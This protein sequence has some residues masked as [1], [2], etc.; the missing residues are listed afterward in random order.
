MG[1]ELGPTKCMKFCANR[2]G[3]RGLMVLSEDR[4]HDVLRDLPGLKTTEEKGDKTKKGHHK[5]RSC[6]DT[7]VSFHASGSRC[8]YE[9]L[10][11]VCIPCSNLV[12]QLSPC[13]ITVCYIL[14]WVDISAS[15]STCAPQDQHSLKP[16]SSRSLFSVSVFPTSRPVR[17]RISKIIRI[18]ISLG[19]C[20]YINFEISRSSFPFHCLQPS[21]G[22]LFLLIIYSFIHSIK[23]FQIFSTGQASLLVPGKIKLPAFLEFF[24]TDTRRLPNSTIHPSQFIF[25]PASFVNFSFYFMSYFLFRLFKKKMILLLEICSNQQHVF[26]AP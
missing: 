14:M 8:L 18:L 25:S 5:A 15:I 21:L 19:L 17:L 3:E 11:T 4:R 22:L 13:V 16:V 26:C 6:L 24:I 23:S 12:V 2:D 10:P 9:E 1:S 20:V 7:S